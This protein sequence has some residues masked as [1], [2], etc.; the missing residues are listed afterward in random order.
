MFTVA[1]G[2]IRDLI[3]QIFIFKIKEKLDY[4]LYNRATLW[5]YFGFRTGVEP[6]TFAVGG[7]RSIHLRYGC[8]TA[9]LNLRTAGDC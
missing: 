1:L 4:T 9:V 2:V 5:V 6:T 8:I 3:F 7:R